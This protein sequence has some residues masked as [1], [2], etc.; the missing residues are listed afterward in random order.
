M[1][2][3]RTVRENL[4]LSRFYYENDLFIE[5]DE[6]MAA[7]CADT[8]LLPKLAWRPS[9]LSDGELLKAITIRELGKSPAVMLV[10]RPENFMQLSENDGLFH[11]LENMVQ[12]GVALIFHSHS[13]RV[14]EIADR[15]LTLA[16]GGIR[17]IANP[18]PA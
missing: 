14:S 5:L 15:R 1:I 9:E 11:H 8:G 17:E 16:A 18:K 4:L 13:R 2:S 6:T 10:D 7:L 12:S 3:N